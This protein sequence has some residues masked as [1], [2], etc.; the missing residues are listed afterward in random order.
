M[1]LVGGLMARQSRSRSGKH[2]Q[3]GASAQEPAT[4]RDVR[5]ARAKMLSDAGGTL[6]GLL[7]LANLE[8]SGLK[9]KPRI[10]KKRGRAA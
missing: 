6:E 3:A 1:M 7:A 2:V 10:S 9:A 5:A 4:V 8:A